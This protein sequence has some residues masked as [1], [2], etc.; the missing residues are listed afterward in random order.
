VK[1]SGVC[2]SRL[3]AIQIYSASNI[4]SLQQSFN[5]CAKVYVFVLFPVLSLSL[6][7]SLSFSLSLSR[8]IKTR[9][10]RVRGI[11]CVHITPPSTIDTLIVHDICTLRPFPTRTCL[12]V[13]MLSFSGHRATPLTRTCTTRDRVHGSL[14]SSCG[15]LIGHP[16]SIQPC[17]FRTNEIF[18]DLTYVQ[19]LCIGYIVLGH[20]YDQGEVDLKKT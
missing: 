13:F 2:K 9:I 14:E 17:T 16:T 7:L 11:S 18:Q 3:S 8:D 1:L 5:L 19:S 10:V 12:L 15:R 20:V 6:S 4:L